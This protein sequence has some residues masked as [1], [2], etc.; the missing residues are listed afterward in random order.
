MRSPRSAQFA[1]RLL[2][3]VSPFCLF[4]V[5][6]FATHRTALGTCPVSIVSVEED[7]ELVVG[8]P[9]T[10]TLA[11]QVTT[12]FAP[13]HD[14]DVLYAAVDFNHHSQFEFASGGIQLQVWSN[15]EALFTSESHASGKLHVDNEHITWTQRM[16]V[17][18]GNLT[19][20]IINGQSQTWGAFG[21]GELSVQVP[22]SLNNLND[23]RPC[24]STQNSGI[25]FASNRVQSLTLKKV[26]A[27]LSN[28]EILEDSN[29]KS[30]FLHN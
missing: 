17:E 16:S 10:D 21:G 28:G 30:V 12:V 18:D 26:R 4:L 24:V 25:G 3:I 11:P 22:T 1:G 19:F 14:T 9:D 8:E 13:V 20:S 15:N 5:V 29:V 7:W 23:Y 6:V 27:T 2:Q